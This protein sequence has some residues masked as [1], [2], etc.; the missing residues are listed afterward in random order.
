MP[1]GRPCEGVERGRYVERAGYAAH[2]RAS[3]G[4]IGPEPTPAK[5]S[6]PCLPALCKEIV[7]AAN[8]KEG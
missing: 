5:H 8:C 4:P 6:A 2:V 1:V 3:S 7:A